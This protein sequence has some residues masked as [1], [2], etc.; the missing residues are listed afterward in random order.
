MA[1]YKDLV[2]QKITKV[3]SNPGEPKTGQMWYN[4]TSGTLRALGIVSAWSSSSPL[5]TA[6]YGSVAAGNTQ[7]AALVSAGTIAGP[8][9]GSTLTEEYNGSGWTGG[10]AYPT[11]GAGL[12]GCGTLTAA[13]GVTTSVTNYYNGTAWTAQPSP[14]HNLPTTK[15]GIGMCGTQTAAVAFGGYVPGPNTRT[16]ATEEYDGE[17]WTATNTMPSS[18]SGPQGFGIQT[19]AVS[20]GGDLGPANTTANAEYNGTSWTA[21]TAVPVAIKDGFACGTQTAGMLAS[22]AG[23]SPADVVSTNFLSYDGTSWATIPSMATSRRDNLGGSN[24]APNI[25]TV[26]G[27]GNNPPTA[28]IANTEEFTS[29]TNT[30]T[31][32]AWSTGGNLPATVS[33]NQGA[34]TQTAALSISG[35][36]NSPGT[37]ATN[38]T[39]HYD[40]SSWTAGGSLSAGA[41]SYSGASSTK[42]SQ[43][44]ALYWNGYNPSPPPAGFR[45]TVSSYDG[46]SWTAQPTYPG[47][48][49]GYGSG[50]GTSTAAL[51]MGGYLV[52]NCY[53]SDGSYNWT[54]GGSLPTAKYAMSAGG[55]QTAAIAAGGFGTSPG[56]VTILNTSDTYNGSSWTSI[57]VTPVTQA[58]KNGC[59]GTSSSDFM[60]AGGQPNSTTCIH[61]D[62]TAWST[63]PSI[64]TGRQGGAGAGA[65]GTS[66]LLAGGQSPFKNATEEFTGETTA[67]NITDFTTS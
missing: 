32:A 5:S 42:G 12:R 46:S 64:S 36:P 13:L 29:S 34:G 65:S 21:A 25:S 48:A 24:G 58:I 41:A 59:F 7:N 27:G 62:G 35:Q 15:S 16:N 37:A 61:Y 39:N 49:N 44:A 50:A 20:A 2:G 23:P 6:R 19:A 54:A 28:S 52:T 33:A 8:Y 4:S 11:A 55:P 26:Q 38:A 51:G 18:V 22:G 40:G 67:V 30:I 56:S 66:G 57:S 63:R 45:A 10:G 43:T 9:A 17:G 60:V 1:A 31:A 14:A 47:S 3:T 53:E